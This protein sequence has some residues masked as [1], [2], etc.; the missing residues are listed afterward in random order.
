MAME[1][2]LAFITQPWMIALIAVVVFTLR[3]IYLAKR[4]RSVAR[5]PTLA[6][7]RALEE[8]KKSL[9]AHHESLE[10]AKGTLQRNLGGARDT[11]RHYKEP[12]DS[13]VRGRKKG[14]QSAMNGLQDFDAPLEGARDT[15]NQARDGSKAA[16][17]SALASAKKTYKDTIPRHRHGAPKDI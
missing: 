14:L 1:S 7:L 11:L 6:D 12:L 16:H 8:A 3:V 9:D 15:L 17:R 13:S 5:H 2:V 10:V 4:L